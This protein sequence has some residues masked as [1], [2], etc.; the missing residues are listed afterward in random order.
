LDI[1]I[2]EQ[3]VVYY[4][5]VGG[6]GEKRVLFAG[7]E[8]LP[9]GDAETITATLLGRIARDGIPFEKLMCFGSDGATVMTG[10]NEGVAARLLRLNPFMLA[11]HCILHR[12]ALAVKAASNEQDFARLTFFPYV[13]QLGRFFRDSGTRTEVF[14][15]KQRDRNMKV[16]KMKLSAFTRWLSHDNTTRI[17]RKRFLPLL[18][19]LETLGLS[20]ATAHGLYHQIGSVAFAGWLLASRDVIPILANLSGLWQ[21]RDLDM[22]AL[23]EQLPVAMQTLEDMRNDFGRNFKMLPQLKDECKEAGHD[24]RVQGG[25][26]EVWLEASIK[27]WLRSLCDHLRMY[28]PN[29]P[30]MSALYRLLNYKLVPSRTK[31]PEVYRLHGLEDLDVVLAHYG[32]RKNGK[33]AVVDVDDVRDGWP[34]MKSWLKSQQ[35]RSII[36][37]V[38]V[39]VVAGDAVDDENP[40]ADGRSDKRGNFKT[41]TQ[42]GDRSILEVVALFVQQYRD[43]VVDTD[44]ACVSLCCL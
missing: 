23:E 11:I 5:V 24:L 40:F 31:R 4:R 32:E 9:A 28:F 43:S 20:D 18:D 6:N 16:R 33:P 34:R 15:Q 8:E 27:K 2:K 19:A 35:G 39:E 30:L 12:E 41:E 14:A 25:R 26:D 36:E 38:S 10:C 37:E 42:T 22:C 21:S 44:K 29:M 7:I 1:S 3:M 17:I 13:E